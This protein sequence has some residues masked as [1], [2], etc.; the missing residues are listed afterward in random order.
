MAEKALI[1]IGISAGGLWTPLHRK[2]T[3]KA[4][5]SL[6]LLRRQL[7]DSTHVRNDVVAKRGFLATADPDSVPAP[8][9]PTD[10][11]SALRSF[12]K[13]AGAYSSPRSLRFPCA[14]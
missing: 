10:S 8:L 1:F 9:A 14:K 11:W 4:A 13:A 7:K 12:R 6:G 3:V 5:T 2:A